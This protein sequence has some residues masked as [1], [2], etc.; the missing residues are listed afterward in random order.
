MVL[1]VA[2]YMGPKVDN[3]TLGTLGPTDFFGEL[4]LLPIEGG[5]SHRRTANGGAELH[6][7]HAIQD[8]RAV[9]VGSIP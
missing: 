1:L 9:G 6:A 5:W 8:G 7:P 3:M 2:G 4:S